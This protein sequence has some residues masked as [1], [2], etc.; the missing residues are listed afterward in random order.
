MIAAATLV[1]C[2]N[3]DDSSE[4]DDSSAEVPT[5]VLTTFE[6]EFSNA[7]NVKWSKQ[8]NENTDYAVADFNIPTR[9]EGDTTC[10]TAFLDWLKGNLYLTTQDIEFEDLPEAVQSVYLASPFAQEQWEIVYV[11]KIQRPGD[12]SLY[13]IKAYYSMDGVSKWWV[14]TTYTE[15]G[16]LVSVDVDVDE[17]DDYWENLVDNLSDSVKNYIDENYKGSTIISKEWDNDTLKV[18]IFTSF[19]PVTIKFDEQYNFVGSETVNEKLAEILKTLLTNEDSDQLSITNLVDNILKFFGTD[20][21]KVN[22]EDLPSAVVSSLNN[23]KSFD[24]DGA[25]LSYKVNNDVFGVTYVVLDKSRWF[26]SY[27]LYVMTED[28]KQIYKEFV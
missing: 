7:T 23:D 2:S 8:S 27:I 24:P 28:G 22:Y 25:L 6:S 16:A 21:E 19:G 12:K 14:T 17:D 13:K 10:F 26:G 15:Q 9:A 18:S 3:D 4:T 20:Y 5:A 1:S 11:K